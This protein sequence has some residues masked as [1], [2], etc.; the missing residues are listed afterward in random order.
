[1]APHREALVSTEWLAAHLSDPGITIVDA[2][3]KLPGIMPTAAEDY[4]RAHI[5]GAVFFDVDAIADHANPLPHMLPQPETFARMMGALGIGDGQKIVIY[6]GAG[7]AA[8]RAWWM[9]RIM[10][11][12]DVAVL[13]GSLRKWRTEGRPVTDVVPHPPRRPFTPHFSPAMV[14][15]KAQLLANLSSR[16]EQVVDARSAPRFAGS[17]PEPRPGLRAGHIPGAVNLPWEQL[18]DPKD[19]TFLP[20]AALEARLRVAGLTPD[21]DVVASCGSGVS[22]CVVAFALHLAGWKEAAVYDG[23]WSEWGLEGD[24]PIATGS[25]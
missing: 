10:G 18:N 9:L 6:D 8:T 13:D 3:F 12:P 11:H 17:A 23:S 21:G 14:R 22:A 20:P 19:G 25:K 15:D 1:M 2:S 24:T 5:P 4:A 7:I 16:R